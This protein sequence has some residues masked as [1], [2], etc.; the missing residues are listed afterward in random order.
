MKALVDRFIATG[1][2]NL[3]ILIN[4]YISAQAH[5][6]T[7]S[8]PSGSLSDGAGLGEPKFHPDL[9][10]F[11]EPWGR[12]QR[13]GPALRATALIAYG[14]WLLDNNY[15]STAADVVWPIVKNDLAYVAQYWN[16]TGF[17]LW[18][19]VK[20]SSFFTTAVQHRALVEGSWFASA[21]G[22]SC[23]YCDSQAPSI[24]C[25]Q[26]TFWNGQYIVSNINE[27]SDHGRSGKDANSILAVI[28]S[29]DRDAL[30]DDITFQPCSPKALANHKQ[31]TDSFRGLYDINNGLES[32][33]AVAVG[34]YAEDVYFNGVSRFYSSNYRLIEPLGNPWYL[35]TL[36]AA[37]QL[38]MA[39][40]QYDQA[41]RIT[42]TDTS[43]AFWQAI[44]SSAATGTFNS[45][46]S[47]FGS[48]TS[49]L[50]SYADGYVAIV[51]KYTPADGS[52]AEQYDRNTGAPL[53]ARDLTWSYASV[54]TMQ[55]ARNNVLPASW[56]AANA[57]QVPSSC[58]P[59]SDTGSYS[60]SNN[61]DWPDFPCKTVSVVLLTFNVLA[62]TAPGQSILVS[63][64]TPELGNWDT[65]N[66]VQL[67][68]SGYTSNVKL[69]RGSVTLSAGTSFEYKYLL[70][71]GDGSVV[72]QGRDNTR[73]TV[74]TSCQSSASTQDNF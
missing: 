11:T 44:Y 22:Q 12:P 73:Y 47:E 65:G 68:A 2:T 62:S 57:N 28:H 40:Y 54:L 38:Y 70:R 20:G 26:Q 59:S 19:E 21:V 8:N 43:L 69:W 3:Q 60:A 55:S 33:S 27:D 6:Q 56:G 23:S 63:G 66:A 72:W 48:L 37:E 4:D 14:R 45:D 49:A 30:C 34:R 13:D 10:A 15:G 36:A 58:S 53:S 64:N 67:E 35:A 41:G 31:V 18:E 29:F 32:S 71:N 50:K 52:M 17:D 39:L 46:S 51:Q 74:P 61:Q 7:I 16:Q 1:D 9:T 5:T 24:L 25:F 42:I